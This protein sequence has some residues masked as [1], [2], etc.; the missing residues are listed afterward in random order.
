MKSLRY[1]VHQPVY[2]CVGS[3]VLLN[4]AI[5]LCARYFFPVESEAAILHY[6]TS[7]GIDFIGSGSQITVI[8]TIGTTLLAANTVL[9]FILRRVSPQAAAMFWAPLPLIQIILG[10]ALF[11]ILRLNT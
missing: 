8:P 2:L 10:G 5:W 9:A 1:Y 4:I 3:A 6:N 11:L 7:V